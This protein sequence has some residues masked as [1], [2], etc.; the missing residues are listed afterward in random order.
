MKIWQAGKVVKRGQV[1]RKD[2]TFSHRDTGRSYKCLT[3]AGHINASHCRV[4]NQ[5][6]FALP[7]RTTN[8][9]AQNTEKLKG[10][11]LVP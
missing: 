9:M 2:K 3:Q 11:V 5:F 6:A 7:P 4:N 1:L 8:S 10:L